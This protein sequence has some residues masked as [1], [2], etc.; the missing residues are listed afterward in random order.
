MFTL[1]DSDGGGKI[2]WS[3]GLDNGSKHVRSTRIG[4]FTS[5]LLGTMARYTHTCIDTNI[6]PLC[7]VV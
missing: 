5:A 2:D 6:R 7:H 1:M 3:N 4:L